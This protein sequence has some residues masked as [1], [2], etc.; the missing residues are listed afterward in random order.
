MRLESARFITRG[1]DLNSYQSKRAKCPPRCAELPSLED[2]FG[3]EKSIIPTSVFLCV[4]HRN[5]CIP[6]QSSWPSLG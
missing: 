3:P 6:D 5:I 2:H 4:I 1:V